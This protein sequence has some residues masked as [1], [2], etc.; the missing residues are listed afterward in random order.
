MTSRQITSLLGAAVLV[1]VA[2]CTGDDSSADEATTGA[3]SNE[4]SVSDTSADPTAAGSVTS[5]PAEGTGSLAELVASDP[6]GL[7]ENV[8]PATGNSGVPS[9]C[10]EALGVDPGEVR[11]RE[12]EG[13]GFIVYFL[14]DADGGTT[15]G[16]ARLLPEDATLED[17]LQQYLDGATAEEQAAGFHGTDQQPPEVSFDVGIVDDVVVVD[18][19]PEVPAE[20]VAFGLGRH[21]LEANLVRT[22]GTRGVSVFVDG[23]PSC[24]NAGSCA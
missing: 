20:Q 23:Q 12:Q 14:C 3:T 17:A 19:G 22:T 5:E 8:I 18:F 21:G 2:G 11:R 24:R 15:Y 1:L 7:E 16:A 4:A 13:E 6:V 9:A 10:S